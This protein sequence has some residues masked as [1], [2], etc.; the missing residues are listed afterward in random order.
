M[1]RFLR[2]D[3]SSISFVRYNV[4]ANPAGVSYRRD[5]K[6]R[7]QIQNVLVIVIVYDDC[8]SYP[9]TRHELGQRS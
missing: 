2:V 3:D 1:C 8:N 4:N 9:R 5:A 6:T 7:E